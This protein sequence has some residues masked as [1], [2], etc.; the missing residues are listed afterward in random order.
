[1]MVSMNQNRSLLED[2]VHQQVLLQQV[3]Q[4]APNNGTQR[5]YGMYKP[6]EKPW[7]STG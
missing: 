4:A 3:K 6:N 2:Y 1:M 5:G 7:E